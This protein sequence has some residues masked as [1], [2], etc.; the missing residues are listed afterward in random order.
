[1]L[2]HPVKRIRWL[3]IA[4]L[5]Q[6]IVGCAP[7][8]AQSD[9]R[10]LRNDLAIPESAKLLKLTADPNTSGTYG[11][12][13]LRIHAVFQLTSVGLDDYRRSYRIDQWRPLPLPNEL[14]G[15]PEGPAELAALTGPGHYF[16]DV[17]PWI[18]SEDPPWTPYRGAALPARLARY[19]VVL[20]DGA[21]SQLHVVY[22]QYY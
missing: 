16:C 20:L 6:V 13:G 8:S 1:M 19:R 14:L 17:A 5:L 12:E 9:E 7:V 15:T 10:S 3:C 4:G 21:T 2:V 11:R 18:A 22:K